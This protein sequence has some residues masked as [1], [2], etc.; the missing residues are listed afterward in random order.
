M[1]LTPAPTGVM[2]THALPIMNDLVRDIAVAGEP[3]RFTTPLDATPDAAGE[4]IYFTALGDT[5]NGLFQVPAG[6]GEVAVIA[7]GDALPNPQGVDISSDDSILYVADAE[8]QQLFAVRLADSSLQPVPGSEGTIPRG[9]EVVQE[10]AVEMIYFSGVDPADGQ[11]AIMK[12]ATTGSDLTVIAKGAP[13]VDPVGIAATD[14]GTLYVVDRSASGGGLG[15]VF[16]IQDGVVSTLAGNVRTGQ[17]PGIALTHDES[18]LLV[19][20]LAQETDSAQVLVIVLASG[21]Q[22]I[23]NKVIAANKGAGGLHRAQLGNTFAW[24]DSPNQGKGRVYR[25]RLP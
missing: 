2:D 6:G 25:V 7:T 10:A 8:A 18:A 17:F 9:V 24:A 13:L 11:P 22:L 12:I 1:P 16:E 21:E 20:T 4:V 3:E 19:S 15:S 23:V 5:G 14:D